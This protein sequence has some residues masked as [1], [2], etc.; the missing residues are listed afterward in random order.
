MAVLEG[1]VWAELD[2]VS[3]SEGAELAVATVST[4]GLD[5]ETA[6]ELEAEAAPDLGRGGAAF[7]VTCAVLQ[8]AWLV[9]IGY[10]VHWLSGGPFS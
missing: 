10:L 9:A 7:L 6:G 2:D 8:L 5:G 1:E 4:E 3:W